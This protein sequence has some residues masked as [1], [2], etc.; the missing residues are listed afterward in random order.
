MKTSWR[1]EM[2]PEDFTPKESNACLQVT[3]VEHPYGELA[4]FMHTLVGHP[5]RWGGRGGWGKAEWDNLV[6]R[7][8]YQ[9]LLALH[10]GTPAGYS[11]MFI[12]D[13]GDVQISTMG[14]APQFV[15]QGLGGVFLT[16]VLHHAFTL[17]SS[18]V[19]LSTCSH[20]H[21]HAK[22]NYEARG[23]RVFEVVESDD[24]QPIPSF[25]GLV[26]AGDGK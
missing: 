12:E 2:R 16:E 4:K 25:W 10:D 3:R 21:P 11:E 18:R 7:P 14:L 19:W 6:A 17:T 26:D 9:M 5:W 15:G 1:M 24:N 13:S 8:D 20:D 22:A 23:F